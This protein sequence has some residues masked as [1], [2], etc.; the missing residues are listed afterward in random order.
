[1]SSDQPPSSPENLRELIAQLTTGEAEPLPAE[2][3]WEQMIARIHVIQRIHRI[4][5]ETFDYFLEVLPPRWMRGNY[6]A[7]AEGQDPLQLF[8]SGRAANQSEEHFTR[9]LT[10]DEIVRFC[11]LSGLPLDYGAY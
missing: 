9:R 5:A 10:N 4:T 8:W 6:F 3:S 7:F 2:E 1:M 11:R